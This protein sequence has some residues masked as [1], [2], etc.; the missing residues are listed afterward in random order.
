MIVLPENQT[1][2]VCYK[3]S[4]TAPNVLLKSFIAKPNIFPEVEESGDTLMKW[5]FGR[6]IAYGHMN[7]T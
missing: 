7:Q 5:G 4:F 6:R 2:Q 1:S 3:V